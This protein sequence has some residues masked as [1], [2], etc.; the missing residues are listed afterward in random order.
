MHCLF[1]IQYHSETTLTAEAEEKG[2]HSHKIIFFK[3]VYFS[4]SFK[5][6]LLHL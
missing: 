2:I 1:V 4:P 3:H 5:Q 6:A